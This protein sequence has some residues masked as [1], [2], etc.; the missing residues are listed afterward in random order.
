[1][2]IPDEEFEFEKVAMDIPDEGLSLRGWLWMSL[3]R[4][5]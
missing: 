1:M 5:R 3:M 2:D 4:Q